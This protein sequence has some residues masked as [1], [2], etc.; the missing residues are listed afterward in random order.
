MS[1]DDSV[2]RWLDGVR[3]GDDQA[4][5]RLWDRYFAQLVELCRRRLSTTPRRT[6]D[7][8]DVALSALNSVYRGVRQGQYP[9][10][11]D[12]TDL[13]R[14]LV[15]I[16]LRKATR[17]QYKERAQKRGEGRVR[18]ES[19]FC[20]PGTESGFGNIQNVG[21]AEP[22]PEMAAIV[23]DLCQRLF[24]SL[25]DDPKALAIVEHKLQGFTDEEI[26]DRLGCSVRTV[27]R[28]LAAIRAMLP[29]QEERCDD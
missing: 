13:W 14:L 17:F 21:G 18:G 6:G 15:V 10:L 24:E 25:K 8:E 4:A 22:T 9:A 27:Y 19:A 2:T 16:A 11:S 1:S 5:Q 23:V 29:D 26:A 28:R 12:R 20:V 7:E 3:D